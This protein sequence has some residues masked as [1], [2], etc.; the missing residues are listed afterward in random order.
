MTYA[1]SFAGLAALA[2]ET[3]RYR[4]DLERY[5][6]AAA[7]F[8]PTALLAQMDCT[9]ITAVQLGE[10]RTRKMAVLSSDIRSFTTIAE[11]LGANRTFEFL[12]LYLRQ[13]AARIRGV[14]GFADLY[15]GDAI[16]ALF[17]N[18]PSEAVTA[19]ID[20]QSEVRAFNAD[21]PAW[22]ER[23]LQTGVGIDAGDVLLGTIGEPERYTTATI[24]QAAGRA[25]TIESRTVAYGAPILVSEA[26][27]RRL[28]P[29]RFQ[30]R[31]LPPELPEGGG[32]A[33]IVFEVCDADDAGVR[34]AK[35]A[36]ATGFAH[37]VALA[38]AGRFED[39]AAAFAAIAQTAPGDLP[40][41]R[42]RDRFAGMRTN[43]PV[44][45]QLLQPPNVA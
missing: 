21:R 36:S 29:R 9:D 4:D 3:K 10:Y 28:D 34:E 17:P 5:N 40:A 37:A 15:I 35:R 24:S 12:N 44:K 14:G 25:D 43:A 45:D 1:R 23:T 41:A 6:D 8:V 13:A 16:V 26:V 33:L 31:R 39:A 11:E 30:L 19:A 38:E 22:F 32:E 2:L 20:L 42:L 7:H 18:D 27:A